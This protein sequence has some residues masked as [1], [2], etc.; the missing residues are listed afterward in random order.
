MSLS[1]TLVDAQIKRFRNALQAL[2]KIGWR[3]RFVRARRP[4]WFA[5]ASLTSR[6]P[7]QAQSCC[8]WRACPTG[9]TAACSCRWFSTSSRDSL[10]SHH[11]CLQLILRS[12]NPAK[13]AFLAINF[14]CSF[15]STYN[16]YGGAMVQ[17]GV[18]IKVSRVCSGWA[19]VWSGR[20]L[21]RRPGPLAAGQLSMTVQT[22]RGP[23]T[24]L[25]VCFAVSSCPAV[26][27]G[28]LPQQPGAP[29]AGG[30]ADRR[31]RAWTVSAAAL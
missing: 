24:T 2:A 15:F 12:I 17:A 14:E 20:D 31:R 10:L 7:L 4:S 22:Q 3:R 1:F 28:H 18:L 21:L 23:A 26:R 13:S 29:H 19:G 6:P 25:C 30:A 11:A 9:Y 27:P 16:V 8:W 5:P